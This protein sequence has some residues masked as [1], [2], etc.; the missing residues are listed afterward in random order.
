MNL[1]ELKELMRSVE[2]LSTVEVTARNPIM[3][4]AYN[5]LLT[6]FRQQAFLAGNLLVAG[7]A[8][9][10]DL[11]DDLRYVA[12]TLPEMWKRVQAHARQDEG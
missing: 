11:A 3:L 1:V 6:R 4:L 12:L 7:K 10:T 9:D 8:V 2:T 5:D